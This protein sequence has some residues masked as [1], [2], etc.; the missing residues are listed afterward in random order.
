VPA[1]DARRAGLTDTQWL[2]LTEA[3]RNQYR[4]A[5]PDPNPSVVALSIPSPPDPHNLAAL[6][7]T[8][9]VH[10]VATA[11]ETD[12]SD[13]QFVGLPNT[14]GGRNNPS[15]SFYDPMRKATA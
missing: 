9:H 11:V 4:A 10:H 15:L 8:D 6:A 13:T 2:A 14:P 7:I 1:S 3:Q 12:E 5:Y